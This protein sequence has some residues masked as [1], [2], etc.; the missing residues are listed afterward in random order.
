MNRSQL[1]G[2]WNQLKGEAGFIW[3]ELTDDDLDRVCGSAERLIERVQERYGYDRAIAEDQVE[4]FLDRYSTSMLR[5]ASSPG[6][7]WAA[8]RP[9][10]LTPDS[11]SS[12]MTTSSYRE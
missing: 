10:P 11:D 8:G 4:R 1:P 3:G 6:P 12:K 9:R 5:L 2:H 7:R